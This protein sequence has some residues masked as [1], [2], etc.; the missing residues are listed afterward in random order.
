MTETLDKVK[1]VLGADPRF[2]EVLVREDGRELHLFRGDAH[3]ARLIPMPKEGRWRME[4]F[5]N[6][7][8][9]ECLDFQGRLEECLEFLSDNP[10]YLFWEG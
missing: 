10:H 3:F 4:L 5:R 1:Q 9:W 6:L 2:A 8:E 7:E